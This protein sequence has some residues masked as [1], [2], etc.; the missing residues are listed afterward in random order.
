ML[1]FGACFQS[2]CHNAR[3]QDDIEQRIYGPGGPFEIV[4]EDVLGERMRVFKSRHSNARE[5]LQSILEFGDR[6]HLVC[7]DRRITFAEHHA[8]IA[9]CAAALREQYAIEPGDRVAILGA[10]TPEWLQ[11]FWATLCLGGIAAAFNSL[12]TASEIEY[13][14]ELVEPKLIVGDRKRLARLERDPGIPVLEIES[15]FAELVDAQRGA[16]LPD[17]PIAEDDPAVI[18]FTSGTTGFP[19][20]A[21]LS[22]RCLV[23]FVQVPASVSALQLALNGIDPASVPPQVIFVTAPFFHVSG[24]FAIGLL[25]MAEGSKCVLREGAFDPE[26]ALRLIE[27]E[28]VTSWAALG[29]VGPRVARHPAREK[30]DTSSL[31]RLSFGGAPTSP[32]IADSLRKAFPNA[33]QSMGMSYGLSECTAIATMFG[34]PE[35][36]QFP[37]AS[38]RPSPTVELE[39]RGSG[40][41]R[42]PEGEKGEIFIRSPYVMLEYWANPEATKA[43]IQ[44]GRWLASGDIGHLEG[45]LLYVHSR[46]RDMIL[47]S[48]ENIYP[49]EIENRLEA[50]PQVREAAVI[51]VDHPEHGQEVKAI[52]VSEAGAEPGVDAL[53]AWCRES[54]AAYKVPTVWE[55]RSEPLP[56]NPAGKVLKTVLTGQAAEPDSDS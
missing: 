10:N 24:A 12:W 1:E 6:E 31:V 40:G 2:T 14:L 33:A 29:S 18:L 42:L 7:G 34:G 53:D 11:A 55:L 49:A 32:A 20:G 51:G 35:F 21:V 54:L 50:H 15:D 23:A 4:E 44:Q 28:R 5:I 56:R 19:K 9:A 25:A 37:T 26:D 3:M 17:Q 47:R 45:G 16:K 22:H 48:A 46:D 8:T 27:R 30:Y 13:G 39:I 41:A 52:V 36:E 38:G 43:V